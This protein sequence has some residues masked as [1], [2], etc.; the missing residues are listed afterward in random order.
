MLTGS[1]DDN[2]NTRIIVLKSATR[3][4][5]EHYKTVIDMMKLQILNE[6]RNRLVSRTK[7]SACARQPLPGAL[8]SYLNLPGA[9]SN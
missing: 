7:N 5:G 1:A 8:D 9:T 6:S 2:V 3:N 4:N